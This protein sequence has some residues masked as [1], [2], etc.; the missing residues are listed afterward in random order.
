M[1]CAC[2]DASP[3]RPAPTR[4]APA[5]EWRLVAIGDSIPYG[6]QDCYGCTPFP[7]LFGQAIT[8]ATKI[9]VR[10]E[11]RAEH[12]GI[13]SR[14]L[15]DEIATSG[16]LRRAVAAADIVIVTIGHNDTP[17]NREDDSCDGRAN[18]P[19][20]HWSAYRGHCLRDEAHAYAHNLDR[21]LAAVEH[22][23]RGQPTLL[24]VTN[25]Y[26]DVIGEPS[27]PPAAASASQHVLD[28][29]SLETCQ[30]AVRHHGACIDSYH[31][32]NGPHGDRDAGPLLSFDHTHPS[33]E[34]H[35]KIAELLSA[36]GLARLP[37]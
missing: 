2:G 37:R 22:L 24:R 19:Q 36:A 34:G 26:T 12:T 7:E 3:S 10:V 29:F 21:V 8:R 33:G 27:A 5:R 14:D 30:A 15:S 23:R 18:G 6:A 1:I 35:Q 4:H 25:D 9:P 16:E 20:S 13:A 32:F 11:N 17:W 31:A 28:A